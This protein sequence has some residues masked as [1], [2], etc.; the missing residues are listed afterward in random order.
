MSASSD[1]LVLFSGGR[2]STVCL[3]WAL[4]RFARVATLGFAYGQRHGVEMTAADTHTC[5]LGDRTQ[6][7]AWGHGCGSCPACELRSRGWEQW[8]RTRI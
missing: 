7:H 4:Q 3:A 5:C 2:D 1:A 8:Q 6:A